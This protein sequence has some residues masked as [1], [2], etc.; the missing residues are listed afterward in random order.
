MSYRIIITGVAGF[1]GSA[2]AKEL[3]TAGVEVVG[4]D[5]FLCGYESNL[6]W[7]DTTK[8]RFT[9][10][11]ASVSDPSIGATLQRGDIVVHLAAVTALPANQVDTVGS[12]SNNVL[13]TLSILEASR[14]KGVAHFIFASSCC[15]YEQNVYTE[16][17]LES[18][19]VSPTLIYSLGKKH[20]EELIQSYHHNYGLPY[21]IFRL[22][23]V[24][25][26]GA[27]ASRLQPGIIPYLIKNLTTQ[28]PICLYANGEQRRDYVFLWDV[29]D[30]LIRIIR[31]N[32]SNTI[33]NV[34]SGKTISVNEIFSTVQ[35][36]LG[37]SMTP[38]YKDASAL[39]N[40]FE[41]LFKGEYPFNKSCVIHDVL[42]FT[43]GDTRKA[44]ELYGWSARTPFKEGVQHTITKS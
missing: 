2:L 15:V 36:V 10:I 34:S 3:C 32:P 12:Y 43:L 24:Y 39:W 44:F 17:I 11:H 7:V 25:G 1:I 16:P 4:I 35:Y 42:K 27:D 14:L 18:A 5:N 38:T 19:T 23:N 20:C 41:D 13:E 8:H 28:S 33:V 26:P 30:L 29:I 37:T 40:R 31:T 21:T 9:L 6:S 22:F